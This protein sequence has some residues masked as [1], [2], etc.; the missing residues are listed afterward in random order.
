MKRII[1]SLFISLF[2][3]ETVDAQTLDERVK[4]KMADWVSE[5]YPDSY[6]GVPHE[7]NCTYEIWNI[8]EDG[9]RM[10]SGF[11]DKK[12]YYG[13]PMG[14]D[15]AGVYILIEDGKVAL[16]EINDF[17]DYK[18]LWD[19]M[20]RNN[21]DMETINR[22]LDRAIVNYELEKSMTVH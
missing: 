9:K 3:I 15:L 5:A 8:S 16:V 13:L 11:K 2:F 22:F 21:Y 14:D 1:I 4:K 6:R 20:Y 19:F 7:I 10:K 18:K 17:P 12:I